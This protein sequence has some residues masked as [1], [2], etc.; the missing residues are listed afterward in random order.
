MRNIRQIIIGASAIA[1]VLV[2]G[3]LFWTSHSDGAQQISPAWQPASCRTSR[4]SWP[5]Q[6]EIEKPLRFEVDVNGDGLIDVLEAE[7]SC[8]SGACRKGVQLTLGG[9]G[10]KFEASTE[11]SFMSI[12][13]INP[14]PKELRNPSH[15]DTLA[16]IEDALFPRVCASPDPSLAWL[17]APQKRL[18]WAEGFPQMPTHYALR[19]LARRVVALQSATNVSG[20]N[21]DPDGEVWLFYAGGVHT[22]N[23][24]KLVELARKGSRVLLG[25]A[26]GVILTNPERSKHAWIYVYPGNGESKLRFPSI[27][28]AHLQGDTAIITLNKN[29]SLDPDRLPDL[30]ARRK[31]SKPLQVRINL[32]TGAIL[33]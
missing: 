13:A 26:H 11:V 12:I 27:T 9:S 6:A 29:T 18:S 7:S 15:H 32:T 22:M 5:E 17:L 2:G 25:T 33:K 24:S 31:E 4:V 21:L 23:A 20:E 8:G 14:V 16:W 1:F 19:L 30:Q 3:T 28:G 10:V